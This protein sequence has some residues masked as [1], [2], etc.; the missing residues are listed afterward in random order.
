SGAV[1][2]GVTHPLRA[3]P[4][5]H[6]RSLGLGLLVVLLLGV[7]HPSFGSGPEVVHVQRVGDGETAAG[8]TP[9]R[10]TEP[11]GTDAAAPPA[12]TAPAGT[13]GAA[14]VTGA[15]VLP[16]GAVVPGAEGGSQPA[17]LFAFP[18]F[19]SWPG[20]FFNPF[21]SL[22]GISAPAGPTP[23]SPTSPGVPT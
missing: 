7:F 19:S 12:A 10:D 17:G 11:D 4:L 22:P 1:A 14:V 6:R 20:S 3:W 9:S 5:R 8:V 13:S 21:R 16:G 2:T 18:A 15:S 23:A